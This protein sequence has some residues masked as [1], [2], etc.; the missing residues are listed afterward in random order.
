MFAASH[1]S[2][3]LQIVE[4]ADLPI[5]T[6]VL[7]V[8]TCLDLYASIRGAPKH[9]KEILDDF[10]Q[11]RGVLNQMDAKYGSQGSAEDGL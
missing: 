8:Q 1:T 3:V 11:M 6:I 10:S 2:L 4:M 5:G 7:L 9:L